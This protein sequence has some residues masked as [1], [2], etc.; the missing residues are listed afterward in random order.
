[1]VQENAKSNLASIKRSQSNRCIDFNIG[2]GS[3]NKVL[4]DDFY[5]Y[6]FVMQTNN[7]QGNDFGSEY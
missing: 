4:M 6:S 7:E 5:K 3:L 1:M 2:Y